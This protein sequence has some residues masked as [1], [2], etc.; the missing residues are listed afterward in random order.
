M[1]DIGVD[2]EDISRFK[3][4]SREND[5]V[6]LSSIFT[7]QEL[8]YCYSK[9]NYVKHLAARFCAKEAFIKASGL[10]SKIKFNE[11]E[12]INLETRKP[13]IC[14]PQK[15]KSLE[16]KLSLSHD[17]DKAIAF[18]YI[19]LRAQDVLLFAGSIGLFIIIALIMYL[20]RN[21]NW[22]NE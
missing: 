2:I 14:M 11:I 4:F 21:V 1:F 12:I 3:N 9:K 20:T 18:F 17:K 22:Y 10:S 13:K 5:L 15:Y 19:L 8:I 6:F 7:E 16:C